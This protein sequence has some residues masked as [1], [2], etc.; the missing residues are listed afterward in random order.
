[1]I[2][3]SQKIIMNPLSESN[4]KHMN[5]IRYERDPKS[6][7]CK[8]AFVAHISDVGSK[9]ELLKELQT[10]LL[11]PDYFGYN[12]DA[13]LDMLCDFNWIAQREVVI[14]HDQLPKL[15][16][17]ELR[18]YIEIIMEAQEAWEKASKNHLLTIIFPDQNATL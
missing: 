14:V 15:D 11:F 4:S 16:P 6:Y 5:R 18:T 3:G 2:Y 8:D 17:Y 1:M 7:E 12:W 9:E 10:H 13:L